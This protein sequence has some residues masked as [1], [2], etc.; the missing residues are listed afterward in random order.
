MT[1]ISAKTRVLFVDDEPHILQGLERVL[2]PMRDEWE[3]LFADSGETALQTMEAGPC[4]VVVS[5]LR[6]PGMNGAELLLA[7]KERYPHTVRLILSAHADRELILQ[8]VGTAHQF[9][10]KPCE[11]EALCAAVKRAC[12]FNASVKSER[13]KEI[14]AQMDCLPSIPSLLNEIIQHLQNE[15]P[16]LE[17]IGAIISKD[18][19][20]TAKLLKLVNSAFFGLRRQV[21]NPVEAVAYLGLET[22]KTLVLTISAFSTFEKQNSGPITLEKV[23]T[24]SLAVAGS[25]R[26]I[27]DAAGAN[28]EVVEES[29]LAGMLHD[30]GKLALAA[31]LPEAYEK[32][33]VAAEELGLSLHAAEEAAFGAH[34]GDIG[35]YLLSLWGLPQGVVDAIA[36]HH[37]PQRESTDRFS[38]VAAVHIANGFRHETTEPEGD[39]NAFLNMRF[40]E[41]LGVAEYLDDWRELAKA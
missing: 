9:L 11:P 41:D 34:H 19:A 22:I 3:M 35:A 15:D 8:C 20:M 24:H 33:F 25:A 7:L 37:E 31:N 39:H 32:V 17:E 14:I 40:I 16:S 4:H 23:W 10:S 5:D 28:K 13:I 18:I 26:K 29:F 30:I 36:L 12:A 6:M 27:A 21:S 38:P 1:E 2:H